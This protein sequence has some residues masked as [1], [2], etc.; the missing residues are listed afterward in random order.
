MHPI[1][2]GALRELSSTRQPAILQRSDEDFIESTLDDLRTPSG[3]QSLAG[4]RASAQTAQGVRKLFQPIQRQFHLALIEAWCDAPGEPRLDPAKL[5]GAGMVLRRVGGSGG[6]ATTAGAT[7]GTGAASYQGW[8][9]SKGRVRGWTPLARVGGDG[10]DPGAEARLR[11]GLTGVADIDQQLKRFKTEN[12]DN[13]LSE[14]VIPLYLAPPDV[15]AQANKTVFYGLVPTT[16]GELCEAEPVF[17]Q[18]SDDSFG[19]H[20]AAFALHLVEGLRGIG[21]DFPFAGQRPVAGWFEAS[22]M[23]GDSAPAGVSADQWNALKNP[24]S[25]ESRQLARLLLLLRQLAGEFNVFEGGNEVDALRARLRK[26]QLPLVS[27]AYAQPRR[28][29]SAFDFFDQA[30]KVLLQKEEGLG[31]LEMPESWPAM[32]SAESG[33]LAQALHAAMQAR[34]KTLKGRAGR[35]DEPDAKYVLRAFVRL[36]PDCDGPGHIVWSDYSEPFVI[37]PWYDGAGAP[38]VQIALPDASDRQLLKALKPNVAFVLPASMQQLLSGKA[39]DLMKGKGSADASGISWICA[40][41]IPAITICAFI[42]LNIFLGLLNLVFGWLFFIKVCIPL[43]NFK[44]P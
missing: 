1:L 5:A 15:C 19:P 35:F 31:W 16:S 13:L 14:H 39:K 40:F 11:N 42:V 26:I 20:S 18:S 21:Q 30:A 9:R 4:L 38:P 36:K 22:E 6:G 8:M 17:S 25:S 23:P 2:V 41:N 24:D 27:Q 37:A 29:V 3:R 10:L 44:K 32:N 7:A 33:K 43:P 28:T 34:F 12:A